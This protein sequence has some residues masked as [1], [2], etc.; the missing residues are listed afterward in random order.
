[1]ARTSTFRFKLSHSISLLALPAVF[2]APMPAL[3]QS[4]S[5][6]VIIT[7]TRRE[8]SIQ[9]VP[10]NIGVV[11]A[12]DI[13]EKGLTDLAEAA[14]WVPGVH[15]IDSGSRSSERIVIRG[16]NA[17]GVPANAFAG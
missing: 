16:L 5:D 15:L 13:Q 1:M 4:V 10:L 7:A 9:D 14:A 8:T 17:R 3:A 12:A 2:A 6:E 11:G